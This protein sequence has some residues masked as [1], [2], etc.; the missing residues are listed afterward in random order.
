MRLLKEIRNLLGNYHTKSGMYHYYRSEY[1]QAVEFLRKALKD[2]ENLSPAERRTARHY[3]TL[4]LM[5]SAAKLE[6]KE[7]F[8]EGAEQLRRALEVN[9][10][11]P[12]IPFRL[13]RLLER[14]GRPEEA[15]RRYAE[16]IDKNGE[17]LEAR[18]ALGFCLLR[19]GLSAEAAEAFRG[20]LEVRARQIE[21]P[22]HRG[23][24]R[25]ER[26]ELPEAEA[27]FREAFLDRPYL[28]ELHLQ[29]SLDRIA[30]EQHEKAL[31]ELNCALE[32]SPGY[33][34]L[35]NLRGVVLC[36]LDR[37]EEAIEA[38]RDSAALNE[39]YLVPRLNLA[40]AYLRAGRYKESE[41]ELE[42]ILDVDPSEPAAIA[43]LE[44]LRSGRLP[45][46]RR[47]VSRGNA[48]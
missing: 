47:P 26:G 44:E 10:E 30:D 17:Y 1:P 20:A 15:T 27:A 9:P 45:E 29:R 31:Q 21:A 7:E 37:P 28:A 33:P 35:H 22:C 4:A 19:T 3:L 38:F 25:L 13:G 34:D 6:S 5:D 48:R 46:K 14:L 11:F 41:I 36:E 39:R 40:F 8:E 32:F 24:E 12:D 42:S 2:S 43:Q 16:A 23:L 18:V